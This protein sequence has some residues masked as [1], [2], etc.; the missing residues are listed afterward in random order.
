MTIDSVPFLT[1]EPLAQPHD[2][3]PTGILCTACCLLPYIAL[4]FFLTA[5]MRASRAA[6][7]LA[8]MPL[9]TS[10]LSEK[11]VHPLQCTKS[12]AKEFEQVCR[13]LA[14]IWCLLTKVNVVVLIRKVVEEPFKKADT[15]EALAYLLTVFGHTHRWVIPGKRIAPL[16]T[17]NN[18]HRVTKSIGG[19]TEDGPT[20]VLQ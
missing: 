3:R 17:C 19:P 2:E 1:T 20:V 5:A 11:Q 7:I 4:F 10:V 6:L 15:V 18:I 12:D 16:A 14:L 9:Q 13:S 8:L